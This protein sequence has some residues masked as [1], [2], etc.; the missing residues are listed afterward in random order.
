MPPTIQIFGTKKCKETAKAIRFFKERGVKIQ[1]IDLA[2]KGPSKG[3]LESIARNVPIEE[4]IDR[5]SKQYKQ[6]QLEYKVFDIWEE[7][8]ADPLLLRKPITRFGQEAQIGVV[9]ETW[10]KWIEIAK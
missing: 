10:K 4:L 8:L 1:F 2:E 6:R 5:E 7:L 9:P 3:E